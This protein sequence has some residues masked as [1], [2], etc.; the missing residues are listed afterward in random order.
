MGP[1]AISL[2]GDDKVH[3]A[4]AF[5]QPILRLFIYLTGFGIWTQY[6]IQGSLQLNNRPLKSG[7]NESNR[8]C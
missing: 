7:F 3:P 1:N 4:V 8:N 2:K 6:L 5:S